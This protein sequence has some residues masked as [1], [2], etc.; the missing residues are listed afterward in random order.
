LKACCTDGC[1]LLF[2]DVHTC[3]CC[4][5][6]FHVDLG[7]WMSRSLSR[8]LLTAECTRVSGCALL[9][10]SFVASCSSLMAV[11]H[12]RMMLVDIFTRRKGCFSA[13]KACWEQECVWLQYCCSVSIRGHLAGVR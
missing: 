9:L 2:A 4:T 8:T 6:F 1:V 5:S 10:G 13:H 7:T 12:V 11:S 3:I